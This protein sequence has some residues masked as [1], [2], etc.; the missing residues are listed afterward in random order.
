MTSVVYRMYDC[1][2]DLLYVGMSTDLGNRLKQHGLGEKAFWRF[3]VR[4]EVEHFPT[5]EAA[6]TAE[7]IAIEGEAPMYNL[8]SEVTRSSVLHTLKSGK[9]A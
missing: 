9:A 5:R 8:D 2:G 7:R 3:V 4:I 1:Y 6:L